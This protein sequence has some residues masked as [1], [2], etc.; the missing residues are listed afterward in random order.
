M[1]LLTKVSE[2]L[3][4]AAHFNRGVQAAPAVVLWPDVDRQ[5]ESIVPMLRSDKMQIFTLGNY[6]PAECRGPAIW[7]KCVLANQVPEHVIPS[8]VVPV[9]YLPGFSRSDLRAI[10]ICPREL[11][12]LAELQ[13]RGALWSQ[14]NAKDWTINA[15]LTSKSGGLGFDVAQD[16]GTQKALLRAAQSKVLFQQKSD[17]LTHRHLDAV[18]FDGLL[19][20]NPT[21]DLLAWVNDPVGQKAAWDV[22]RWGIFVERCRKDYG[23][24]PDKDGELAAA[25]KLAGRVGAWANIWQLYQD[26]WTSFPK[27][28]DL[29]E[30]ITP[31]APS[32]LFDDFSAYPK[33]N[34]TEETYLRDSLSKLGALS[35][36]EARKAILEAGQR[37]ANRRE[38]LWARMGRAPLAD[39]IGHLSLIAER[40]TQLPSGETPDA[41]AAGYTGGLWQIDSAAMHALSVVHTKADTDA[42]SEAL[43]ACYVL[44]LE[45]A[46]L[47]FQ[48]AVRNQGSLS[49]GKPNSTYLAKGL[50]TVFVDGLRYDVALDLGKR[51]E[52]LGK[53]AVGTQWT[54]IPSVTSSGKAWVSPVA[55]KIAG[56][57]TDLEFLP[58]VASTGKSLST[59][60]FRKLLEDEGIQF[61]TA[62]ETGDPSGCAWAECGDLD[63]FGHE[64]QLRLARD[65]PNQLAQIVERV[66]ELAASG[67]CRFRI[68]TD[69]GWLLVPGGLFKVELAKSQTETRWGRCAVLKESS[70]TSA[71]TFGWDWCKQV[72]IAFAP[73]ISSFFAGSEYAHGGLSLQECLIPVIDLEIGAGASNF[74]AVEIA[75]VSWRG[76]RCQIDV[77]PVIP[78]L[79]VDI[80]TKAAAADSSMLAT[81]KPLIEGKVSLVVP[82]DD[83]TLE[84][85]AAVVVILDADGK[86]IQKANTTIGG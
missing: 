32:G 58:G 9:I 22:A 65:L 61:I 78:G 28:V 60:N 75:K 45:Q 46:A 41:L 23:F 25:E 37:H 83:S 81:A 70:M 55:N 16:Q 44:W 6:A 82:D 24:H 42:V 54:S 1:T 66:Q 68:V 51:L 48:Y 57:S 77:V 4:K 47:R 5:W 31:P 39:A 2:A 21:R 73:G 74:I 49:Q 80:R 71:L 14:L 72:Q 53:V 7:L 52:S 20:P 26:S 43:K 18:W 64:H 79:W 63:H 12:P 36:T 84:G 34:I 11:Q 33:W 62:S 76:M 19:A 85:S 35:V 69:H 67:W 8:G 50:C 29:L 40:S 38:S 10:E 17:E 15:F 59:H 3:R 86:V 56:Q 13:Y 27:V 30:R